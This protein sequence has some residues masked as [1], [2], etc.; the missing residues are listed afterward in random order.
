MHPQGWGYFSVTLHT[1]WQ[2]QFGRAFFSS[3]AWVWW[4][5]RIPR[6]RE[7]IPTMSFR[8]NFGGDDSGGDDDAPSLPAITVQPAAPVQTPK[9]HTLADLVHTHLREIVVCVHA[10]TP[11]PRYACSRKTYP[12][13]LLNW[14]RSEYQEENS[15]MSACS[16]WRRTGLI[17][18]STA[19][20]RSR[21]AR[22]QG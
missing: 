14:P 4:G 15:T 12:T 10:D 20:S 21:G 19:K 6:Q 2:G 7:Y 1:A 13:R 18:A 5:G 8:F 22:W 11:G 9:Y 16:S 3:F 17:S